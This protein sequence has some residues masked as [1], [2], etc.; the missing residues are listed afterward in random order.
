MP[1]SVKKKYLVKKFFIVDDAEFLGLVYF[2]NFLGDG[3][4]GDERGFGEHPIPTNLYKYSSPT[5]H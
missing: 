4:S 2:K 1:I 5:I 3:K